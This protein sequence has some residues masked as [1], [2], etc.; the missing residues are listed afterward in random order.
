MEFLR[1][2][3]LVVEEEDICFVHA[4]AHNP[5]RWPYVSD[6]LGAWQCAEASGKTYTFV[7]HVHEPQLY[8]QTEIGKLRRFA[9]HPGR[10]VPVSRLRRWVS[11]VGSMGQ[12]RDGNPDACMAVFE[13]DSELVTFHR[14]AYDY[15]TAAEKVRNAGLPESLANR[16]IT[17]H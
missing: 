8:Y 6:D 11:V 14:V 1:G 10:E 9:P 4:S 13:P 15:Y 17:G 12:P 16:L 5:D 7:G 2:L 3:P